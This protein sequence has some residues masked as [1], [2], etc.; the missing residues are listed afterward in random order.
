MN[1]LKKMICLSVFVLSLAGPF[2]AGAEDF[3]HTRTYFGLVGTSVGIDS[4]GLFNGTVYSRSDKPTYE[5]NLIPA[6]SR[7]FGFGVLV[8]HREDAYSAE[9]SFSQSVQTAAFGPATLTSPSGM[10]STFTGTA[11]DT[12]V[13]NAINLDFKR[14]FLTEQEIQPFLNLGV[15]F[16]WIVVSNSS[17][18][19]NGKIGESS[20]FGLGLDLGIGAEWYLDS[21]FSV[22]GSI[23]QRWASFDEV[24]GVA[25]SQSRHMG[26]IGSSSDEGSGLTFMIGTTVGFY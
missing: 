24:K 23:L 16:P 20:I 17:A 9:L 1:K 7:N 21:N 14:Y 19:G 2:R 5:V 6:L 12:A 13:I 25:D 8:G 26:L 22:T 15:S 4:G 11:N 18:D 10:S 3:L